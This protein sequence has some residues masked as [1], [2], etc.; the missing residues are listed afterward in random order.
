MKISDILIEATPQ[1]TISHR[2]ETPVSPLSKEARDAGQRLLNKAYQNT[3]QG[4]D[5]AEPDAETKFDQAMGNTITT[6]TI[7]PNL[8][9]SG[10][11]Y[12]KDLKDRLGKAVANVGKPK[13]K[14]TT[15]DLQ[16]K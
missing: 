16:S 4:P 9:Q 3:E 6:G 12:A 2:R 1:G 5:K 10:K 8:E 13:A 14:P 7:D 15:Q 11:N